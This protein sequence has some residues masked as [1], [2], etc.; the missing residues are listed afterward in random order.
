MKKKVKKP[1]KD[2]S[3]YIIWGI[4]IVLVLFFSYKGCEAPSGSKE[5]NY[6]LSQKSKI[7]NGYPSADDVQYM[8]QAIVKRKLPTATANFRN[9]PTFTYYEN[10]SIYQYEGIVEFRNIYNALLRRN[11]Y[12][13]LKYKGGDPE[14][15]SSYE[16][17]A[18]ILQ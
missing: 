1:K 11:Y 6:E 16:T 9:V 17:T 10:L 7:P 13:Q 14:R 18:F 8:A 4:L 15:F 2:N 5:Y 12:I 3:G